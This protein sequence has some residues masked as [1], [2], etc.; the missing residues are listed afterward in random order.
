MFRKLAALLISL[1]FAGSLQASIIGTPAI[2]DDNDGAVTCS[3]VTWDS[4]NSEFSI[5]GKQ[6]WGPG[7]I[8]GTI[9]TDT[10]LDPTIKIINSIDN[11][12]GFSW[13]D[14]Q[15]DLSMNTT[16]TISNAAVTL[17]TGWTASVTQ[18]TLV[19]GEYVGQIM[20]SGGTP[21]AVNDSLD[22]SYKMTFAGSTSYSYC[23]T[24]TPIPEP[25]SMASLLGFAG[26][27]LLR[28]R[29]QA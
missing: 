22:F 26:L 16:F 12:T 27:A 19:G 4:V 20:Y 17:P 10:P 9:T 5:A 13:T 28:R 24:L 8:L 6:C 18:P 7:H 3:G 1:F 21:V 11:D 23:Q 14:F 25:V 15:V 29:H 2:W